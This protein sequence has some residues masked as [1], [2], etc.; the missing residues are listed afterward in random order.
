MEDHGP[1]ALLKGKEA[2]G[3]GKHG[4]KVSGTFKIEKFQMKYDRD[5]S[6]GLVGIRGELVLV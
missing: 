1:L 5:R 2:E 3:K 6:S 4:R